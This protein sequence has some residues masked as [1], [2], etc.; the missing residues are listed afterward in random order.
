MSAVPTSNSQLLTSP[1]AKTLRELW[2]EV[3][4]G[5]GPK[6]SRNILHCAH[7]S[8]GKKYQRRF[9]LPYGESA[10]GWRDLGGGATMRRRYL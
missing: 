4:A 5:P 7:V 9:S 8:G 6:R 10:F 2:D 3:C 1:K